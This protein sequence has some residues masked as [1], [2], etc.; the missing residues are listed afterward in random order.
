MHADDVDFSERVGGK[1]RSYVV[2]TGGVED[3]SLEEKVERLR[4]EVEGVMA[5]LEKKKPE[6]DGNATQNAKRVQDLVGLLDVLKP[7]MQINPD[8][9]ANTLLHG[10]NSSVNIVRTETGPKQDMAEATTRGDESNVAAIP[11]IS[12]PRSDHESVQIAT[13][14][15]RLS[16]L[17][18]V[19]GISSTPLPALNNHGSPITILP[20]LSNLQAQIALLLE[21]SPSSIDAMTQRVQTLTSEAQ[22]LSE[23]RKTAKKAHEDLMASGIEQTHLQDKGTKDHYAAKVNALYG[24]LG[25]IDSLAPLLPALLDRL[26]S[27]RNIHADAADAYEGIERAYERQ[28][29]MAEEIK[30]W[31]EGLEKVEDAMIRGEDGM[32][33]NV[34]VV[35]GWVAK[36][37][38]R[39]NLMD[40]SRV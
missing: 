28:E 11:D 36:L 1:R 32:K 31:K 16:E 40:V 37:E 25:T 21:S 27:L 22:Q 8:T 35:E 30:K 34:K 6:S 3:E 9:K 5:E 2:Y 20:T 12:Q 14:D 23:A 17:E 26:K 13:F 18:S 4:R 29:S 39:M 24:T 7:A 10:S 19:L 15:S 38:A 33:K